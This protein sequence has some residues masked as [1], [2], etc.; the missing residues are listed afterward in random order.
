MHL[1]RTVLEIADHD[2]DLGSLGGLGDQGE[3]VE[4]GVGGGGVGLGWRWH[5]HGRD[6]CG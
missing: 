6:V 3:V 4:E 1:E 5:G 2:S